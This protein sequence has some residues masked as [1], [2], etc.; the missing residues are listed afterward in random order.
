M[1]TIYY[2]VIPLVLNLFFLALIVVGFI[3]FK[4]PESGQLIIPGFIG[5]AICVW[6]FLPM[7][8]FS[9]VM[10]VS[11][12]FD[13]YV[14]LMNL[15]MSPIAI[16]MPAII[17]FILFILGIVKR[18]HKYSGKFRLYGGVGALI[19]F[20]LLAIALPSM[21][22]HPAPAADAEVKANIQTIRIALERYGEDH[23]G[24]YPER[25]ETLID[26]GFMAVFPRNPFIWQASDGSIDQSVYEDNSTYLPMKNVP[27]GSPDFEGNFTYLTVIIDDDVVGFYLIGYGYKK[28]I[29]E[30]LI[31]PDV[32]DHVIIVVES[33]IRQPPEPFPTVQDVILQSQSSD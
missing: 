3:R 10:D 12:S 26:D 9:L 7:L 19:F 18:D 29:G 13:N 24:V 4:K 5:L 33:T 32:E 17:L 11:I 14:K 28:T 31:S 27:Y 22:K 23:S 20:F 21:I 1:A 16:F 15:T 8:W 25:I 2:I 30:R 6:F